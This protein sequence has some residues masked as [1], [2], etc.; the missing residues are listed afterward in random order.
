MLLV[1]ANS[2]LATMSFGLRGFIDKYPVGGIRNLLIGII[3]IWD[4]RRTVGETVVV[5][6]SQDVEWRTDLIPT[7]TP[8]RY[9]YASHKAEVA[10]QIAL[11][12]MLLP[13]IGVTCYVAHGDS[14]DG[15]YRILQNVE[16][17]NINIYST[18]PTRHTWS[19]KAK[20]IT[21]PILGLRKL[22]DP[23]VLPDKPRKK[24][25]G[26]TAALRWSMQGIKS[27]GIPKS[28]L[29]HIRIP[30][31]MSHPSELGIPENYRGIVTRNW[32]VIS[33]LYGFNTYKEPGTW[34]LGTIPTTTTFT[35]CMKEIGCDDLI[36]K[37][38]NFVE[39]AK[40]NL[41]KDIVCE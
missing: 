33:A 7:Y 39:D 14:H 41:W 22:L 9:R 40:Q 8:M 4:S 16:S 2:I 24:V 10:A 11:I 32:K 6:G 36:F 12:P 20:F 15:L 34:H 28:G 17:R 27:L 35:E 3:A 1:D 29:S 23:L 31:H 13:L 25:T 18:R 5:L 21:V 19:R 38:D 37:Y 30:K 26:E